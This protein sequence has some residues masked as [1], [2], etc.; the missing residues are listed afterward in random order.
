MRILRYGVA[1]DAVDEIVE[2]SE[3]TIGITLKKFCNAKVKEFDEEYLRSPTV[4]GMVRILAVKEERDFP[5]FLGIIDYRN[6]EWKN[7]PVAWAG[8]F[9]GKEKKPTVAMEAIADGELWFLH[10]YVGHPRFLERSKYHE[11]QHHYT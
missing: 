10:L 6:W 7:C 1:Y 9:K 11:Q 5:G 4:A 8:Q 2:V 3:S